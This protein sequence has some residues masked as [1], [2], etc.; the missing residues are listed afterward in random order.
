MSIPEEI[1]Y[2]RIKNLKLKQKEKSANEAYNGL[3]EEKASLSCKIETLNIKI[4]NEKKVRK[5]IEEQLLEVFKKESENKKVKENLIAEN[6]K[7][8][9]LLKNL[10]MEV[11]KNKVLTKNYESQISDLKNTINDI[12]NNNLNRQSS[13]N[14]SHENV[15]IKRDSFSIN[16]NRATNLGEH[17]NNNNLNNNNYNCSQCGYSSNKNVN[18][19]NGINL[20]F[21]MEENFFRGSSNFG[22]DSGTSFNT[23]NNINI[24][25][26]SLTITNDFKKLNSGNSAVNEQI[27]SPKKSKGK[28][29]YF[30]E[31]LF[32][33]NIS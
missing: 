6:E 1:A 8:K 27:D 3:L 23:N 22:R 2:L 25:N 12:N 11:E 14:F 29:I 30:I 32:L 21:S 16:P 33:Y 15:E 5:Q 4:K 9:V 17:N 7:F 10:E 19:I 31:L 28:K 26:Q 13:S 24:N 20:K 18:L